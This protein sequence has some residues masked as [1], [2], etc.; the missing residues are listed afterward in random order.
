M[1]IF[2]K[3]KINGQDQNKV[4][5]RGLNMDPLDRVYQSAALAV[6]LSELKVVPLSQEERNRWNTPSKRARELYEQSE[7]EQTETWRE[8]RSLPFGQ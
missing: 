2:M 4:E 3:Q 8:I 7:N 1:V 5:Q 6:G